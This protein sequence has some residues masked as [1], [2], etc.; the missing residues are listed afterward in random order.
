MQAQIK[1]IKKTVLRL[2]LLDF[3][4]KRY[5]ELGVAKDEYVAYDLVMKQVEANLNGQPVQ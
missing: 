5:F 2:K 1:F 4:L 3:F